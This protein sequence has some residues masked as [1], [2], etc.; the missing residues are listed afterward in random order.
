MKKLASCEEQSEQKMMT[1]PIN[2]LEAFIYI[3]WLISYLCFGIAA[4][5]FVYALARAAGHGWYKSKWDYF[6]KTITHKG[7][8]NGKR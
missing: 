2:P 3:L 8:D 6:R 7:E 5:G 4:I 1:E